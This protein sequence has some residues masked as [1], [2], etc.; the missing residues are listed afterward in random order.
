MQKNTETF[1]FKITNSNALRRPEKSASLRSLIYFGLFSRC[2]FLHSPKS[3]KFRSDYGICFHF[4][5]DIMSTMRRSAYS[6]Y[7][8]TNLQLAHMQARGFTSSGVDVYSNTRARERASIILLAK[9][10][11]FSANRAVSVYV[12]CV[13][14]ISV[15]DGT[16]IHFSFSK[17]VATITAG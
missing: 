11:L 17:R 12:A 5:G 10:P 14:Y 16:K 3:Y 8:P 6:V 9:F 1:F 7:R 13:V 4:S 2:P 15:C